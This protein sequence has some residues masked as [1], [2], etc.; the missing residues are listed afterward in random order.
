MILINEYPSTL[1]KDIFL[2]FIIE[3]NKLHPKLTKPIGY[4]Y[5]N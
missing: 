3:N 2:Y 4:N 5:M 1:E